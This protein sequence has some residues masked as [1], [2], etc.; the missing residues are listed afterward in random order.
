MKIEG[1]NALVEYLKSD[2]KITLIEL[3]EN[4]KASRKLEVE[5]L[6]QT[7][8]IPIQ[9]V[10]RRGKHQEGISALVEEEITLEEFET[11]IQSRREVGKSTI[12]LLDQVQD[13]RN[14]GAIARSADA[15]GVDLMILPEHGG[16]RI[17]ESAIKSSTGALSHVP[18]C[19]VT[20]LAH[21]VERLKQE[22]YWIYSVQMDGKSSFLTQDYSEK[23]AI[24]LGSE[25]FGIRKKLAE[26]ADFTVSIPMSGHVNSLNVSVAAGIILSVVHEKAQKA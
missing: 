14:L 19:Y 4:V 16:A 7:H 17:S 12:L 15:F 2:K 26:K 25:G 1:Y 6:A 20:N 8:S 23:C 5:N 3:Y 11:F 24:L 21:A 18:L 13:P 9:H 10:K 22:G